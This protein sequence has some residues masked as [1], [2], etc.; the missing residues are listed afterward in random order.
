[1]KRIEGIKYT[2]IKVGKEANEPAAEVTIVASEQAWQ[3]CNDIYDI[4]PR[5]ISS[6][7]KFVGTVGQIRSM[8][9]QLDGVADDVERRLS[10]E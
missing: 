10:S 2:G 4:T 9:K 8:A 5:R 6:F 3:A 1:M 7:F